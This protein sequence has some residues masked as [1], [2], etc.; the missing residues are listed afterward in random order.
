LLG[1][2]LVYGRS[3][4]VTQ[5]VKGKEV[6]LLVALTLDGANKTD[7]WFWPAGIAL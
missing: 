7:G 5:L 3:W 6:E 1:R 4:C 2:A